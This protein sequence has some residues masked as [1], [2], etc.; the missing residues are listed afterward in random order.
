MARYAQK[1]T[2]PV[3]K[4]RAETEGILQRYG[5]SAFCYGYNNPTG[6]SQVEFCANERRIRF[7]LPMPSADGISVAKFEQTKRQRWR[8]LLI[9]IKAKLEAVECG[10]SEFEDEFLAFVVDPTTRRTVGEGLRPLL[11]ESYAGSPHVLRLGYTPE[12]AGNGK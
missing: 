6:D 9:S 2:V 11:A 10:I 4:S 12:G 1:T 5:A 7:M 8:A 3:E